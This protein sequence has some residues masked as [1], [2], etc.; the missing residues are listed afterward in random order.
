VRGDI[1]LVAFKTTAVADA[2]VVPAPVQTRA[3]A[4]RPV[5][6][7][8]ARVARRAVRQTDSTLISGLSRVL[9][10]LM[11]GV[12]G[13]GALAL[14]ATV[15]SPVSSAAT[16]TV[17]GGK[18]DTFIPGEGFATAWHSLRAAAPATA[19][20][21]AVRAEP[22]RVASIA[23]A[24]RADVPP[25][26]EIAPAAIELAAATE[27]LPPVAT[28]SSSPWVTSVAA[29]PALVEPRPVATLVLPDVSTPARAAETKKGA[30]KPRS[31]KSTP[32]AQRHQTSTSPVG[33]GGPVAKPA[34][35]PPSRA[36]TSW[37]ARAFDTTR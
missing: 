4:L 33:L 34:S 28:P 3:V 35:A 19:M 6:R 17:A 24:A 21:A 20:P 8:P 25:M 27:T 10:G 22:I 7:A 15:D 1:R 29:A 32:S 30:A 23:L 12:I 31:G 36:Q 13:A 2:E 14:V 5:S 37:T 18:S 11:V 9:N 26:V 16:H